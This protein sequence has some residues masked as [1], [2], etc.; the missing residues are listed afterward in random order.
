MAGLLAPTSTFKIPS[1]FRQW[2]NILLSVDTVAG[3]A[4]FVQIPY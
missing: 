2:I 4:L 1:R 3:T